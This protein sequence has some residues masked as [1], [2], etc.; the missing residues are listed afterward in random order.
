MKGVPFYGHSQNRTP[1]NAQPCHVVAR[2]AHPLESRIGGHKKR[3]PENGTAFGTENRGRM[4]D[5]EEAGRGETRAVS[6]QPGLFRE[7]LSGDPGL[8]HRV[9]GD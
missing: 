6:P 2:S 3:R 1:D 5:E 7:D 4:R 8:V 9:C